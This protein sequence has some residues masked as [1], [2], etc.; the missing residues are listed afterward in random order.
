M[1][2]A[3][4]WPASEAGSRR[5]I[6]AVAKAKTPIS[7]SDL[8]GDR[9]AEFQQPGQAR[10]IRRQRDVKQ[11]RAPLAVVVKSRRQTSTPTM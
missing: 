9:E 4:W 8:R 11:S 2:R 3:I 1:F 6:R 7:S 5:A 10:P